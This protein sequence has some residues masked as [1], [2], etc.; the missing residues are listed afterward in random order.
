[1]K[2]IKILVGLLIL[3]LL[4]TSYPVVCFLIGK[5]PIWVITPV[6]TL[7]GF[8]FTFLHSSHNL[9]VKQAGLLLV[10]VFVIS[11]LLESV[12]V[13]TGLVYGPY[14][15]TLKLGPLFLGLVPYL[16]PVAWFMMSY[17]SMVMA[18][19]LVPSAWNRWTRLL[20]VSA[21]G[22]L[23]MTAW[24]TVMDP[25]MVAGGHW[26]WDAKGAY[27][28][29][30]LQNFTGWWL[31]VFLCF[32]VYQLLAGK[33]IQPR[34]AKLDRLVVLSYLVTAA[35]TT[36]LAFLAGMEGPALTGLFAMLPWILLSWMRLAE[37]R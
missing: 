16:I 25:V 20:A 30:P 35:G 4:L 7:V 12:G 2:P 24:D 33:R 29:I 36:S 13:A 31:T 6:T 11:L 8:S 17:P 14:H 21:I 15:Y 37:K 32:L 28:G 1:M 27:Y 26:V 5:T 9:G 3:F 19:W 34:N 18:D 23:I 10:C 22:G